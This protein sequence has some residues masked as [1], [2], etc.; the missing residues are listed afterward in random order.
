MPTQK[1]R[2]TL[3]TQKP[4]NEEGSTIM[5]HIDREEFKW[6]TADGRVL[7]IDEIPDEHLANIV[8]KV[9]IYIDHYPDAFYLLAFLR[10]ECERRGLGAKFMDGAPHS[11]TDSDGVLRNGD[12]APAKKK[13]IHT[14]LFSDLLNGI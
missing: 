7:T 13:Q 10:M 1:A 11:Y 6:G 12:E 14:M 8:R 3:L 2:S 4:D 5:A 9:K